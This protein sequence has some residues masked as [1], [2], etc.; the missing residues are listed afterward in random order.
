[1]KYLKKYTLFKESNNKSDKNIVRDV[2]VAMSLINP[3]FLSDILDKGQRARYTENNQVFITDLKNL[4]IAKNRFKLGKFF[5]NKF[6]EDD[7][8]SKLNQLFSDVS[9]DFESDWNV[10]LN[11]RNI[12]RTIVDKLILNEKLTPA[13][14]KTIYWNAFKTKD[15]QEDIIIELTEGTQFSFFLNKN[16]NKTKTASFNKLGDELI[17]SDMDS[18]YKE[19]YLPKW[20]KLIQEWIKL[21][22]ENSNKSIQQH[23]EKFINPKLIDNIKYF[24]YFNIKHQDPRFRHLGEFIP[25]LEKNILKFSDLLNDIWKL[26][27]KAFMDW[28]RTNKNWNDIRKVI[29][30][31]RILEKILTKSLKENFNEFITK[32][33]NGYKKAEGT[34]KMRLFKII[35]DKM[36]CSERNFY[37]IS[38]SGDNFDIIPSRKFFRDNYDNFE[39]T[40]N[41]HVDFNDESFDHFPININIKLDN[42]DFIKLVIETRFSGGEVSN[43]L[44]SKYK[45]EF[46]L[47]FNFMIIKKLDNNIY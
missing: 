38:K 12:S 42:K 47:D 36:G 18:L 11:S 30:N 5:N 28:E 6:V 35:V 34:L 15:T 39:I 41:Y 26:E 27:D 1:M 3:E 2:C 7:E 19:E 14:I 46:P 37:Y 8:V 13:R 21:V 43:S 16:L 44:S 20:D 22:Y 32:L 10:L 29:L 23:I 9:F 4:V 24:E 25:E 31:S 33:D 40:F 17:G 45:F